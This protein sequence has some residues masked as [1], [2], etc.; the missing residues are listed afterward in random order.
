MRSPMFAKSLVIA[1]AVLVAT[2]ATAGYQKIEKGFTS[3]DDLANALAEAVRTHSVEDMVGL[4]GTDAEGTF[5]TG[6]AA[7]D[8]AIW[9]SFVAAFDD[10][11][12]VQE[13]Y[14]KY[15]VLLVGEDNWAFPMPMY[16]DESGYW[17]FDVAEGR[18]E[19]ARRR[20][21]RNELETISILESYVDVQA[22]YRQTDWDEDGVLEFAPRIIS[23]EG[24]RDGLYWSGSA[25]PAGEFFAR[26]AAEGH[27]VD[28]ED[29]AP[30]PYAGYVYRL[31]NK[32]G[33]HAPGGALDYVVNGNQIAGHAAIAVPAEYG[34]TGIM[35]FMVAENGTI[36]EFD[37]GEQ[38][39]E[40][41]L[42]MESFDPTTDWVPV[43]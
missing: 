23:S 33:E 38:G 36:L 7:Q 19:M 24:T 13:I 26:A 42:A 43:P 32:Q 34:V 35:S 28:G 22:E 6:N 39:L 5:T 8:R 11:Y 16:R 21:G 20:I 17:V 31:F 10:E 40:A 27:V 41:S 1:G 2:S 4:F 9:T 25:S 18:E 37:L 3:A 30:E 12:F 14:G 15:A 29:A